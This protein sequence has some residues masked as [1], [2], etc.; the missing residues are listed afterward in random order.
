R[1][2]KVREAVGHATTLMVDANQSWTID[3][4]IARIRR[5]EAY[6]LYWIEEPLEATDLGGFERLGDHI[7]T[8]RAGGESLYGPAAFHEAVR[9]QALDILQPEVARVGGI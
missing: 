2:A 6:Q 8:A 9:R 3:H 1:V 7:A 5:L 4:A